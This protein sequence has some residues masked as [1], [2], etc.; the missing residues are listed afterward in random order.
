MKDPD[1]V[2]NIMASWMKLDDLEGTKTIRYFTESNDMKEDKTFTH[3]HQFGLHLN[4]Q[5]KIYYHS[6]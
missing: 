2:A 5:N 3:R 1:Y 4:Q 6:E